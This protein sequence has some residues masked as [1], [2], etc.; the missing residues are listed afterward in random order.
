ML[1]VFIF[2]NSPVYIGISMRIALELKYIPVICE[3]I[4]YMEFVGVHRK[5]RQGKPSQVQPVNSCYS[6]SE[7]GV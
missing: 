3:I 1:K 6:I 7:Q 5:T 2:Y 4:G